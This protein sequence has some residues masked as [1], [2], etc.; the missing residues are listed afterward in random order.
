MWQTLAL[1]E[2][3]SKELYQKTHF[4]KERKKAYFNQIQGTFICCIEVWQT[5]AL[6]ENIHKELYKTTPHFTNCSDM[7]WQV[8]VMGE[9]RVDIFTAWI[10]HVLTRKK[11]RVVLLSSTARSNFFLNSDIFFSSKLKLIFNMS[12]QLSTLLNW[13]RE[14]IYVKVK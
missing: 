7:L 14:R 6:E 4:H 8:F 1:E 9:R 3:I 2:N 13:F 12:K 11:K 5:S 10:I